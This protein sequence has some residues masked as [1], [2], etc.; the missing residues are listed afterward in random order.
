MSL[1]GDC[2][3]LLNWLQGW[4]FPVIVQLQHFFKHVQIYETYIFIFL[5]NI[6]HELLFLN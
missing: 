5:Q 4:L 2:Y 6:S 3:G 1:C